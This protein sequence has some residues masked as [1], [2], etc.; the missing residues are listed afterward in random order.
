MTLII[1]EHTFIHTQVNTQV[2]ALRLPVRLEHWIRGAQHQR[3]A[4]AVSRANIKQTNCW[5]K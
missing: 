1:T 2:A 5:S 4:P 3:G